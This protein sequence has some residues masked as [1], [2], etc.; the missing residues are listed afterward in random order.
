MGRPWA[1]ARAITSWMRG[2]CTC[3]P[4]TKTASAQR[5]SSSVAAREFSSTNRTSHA[6]GRY[7]ATASSP[8]GGMNARTRPPKNGYACWK[9]P[10][11]RA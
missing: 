1:W 2:R 10:N 3:M 9:V 8:W 11:E 5:K 7:A 6:S 4:E